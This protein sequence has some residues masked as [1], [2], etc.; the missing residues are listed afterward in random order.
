MTKRSFLLL[1]LAGA[2]ALSGCGGSGSDTTEGSAD[3]GAAQEQSAPATAALS[4]EQATA[5]VT[6]LAG[7]SSGAQIMD[8]D[9]IAASLP[10]AKKLIEQMEI[11]PEKCA[12]FVSQQ[13]S[14][15]IE[16]INMAVAVLMDEATMASTSYSV[17]GYEDTAKLDKITEQAKNKDLQGCDSFSMAVSGQEVEA[18]A[19]ILDASSDADLTYATSS[20]M[21]MN[22]TEV[23]GGSYQ[24]QG[25]VGNN[26]VSVAM[27]GTGSKSEAD[28][29]K[30]LTDELNKA[31]A[32]VKAVAK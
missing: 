30:K 24:M 32:E 28:M 4:T 19:K 16:G 25:L 20:A 2:L 10:Q 14:W 12:E 31:V 26:A 17:A 15:D 21:K 23:P 27:T 18:S 8:G 13:G 11:K 5:I 6:K 9:T 3:A 7:D 29:L 1:P 22:G